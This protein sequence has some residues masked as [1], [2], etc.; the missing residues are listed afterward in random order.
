MRYYLL[1]VAMLLLMLPLSAWSRLDPCYHTYDEIIA[2]LDSL[3][4]VYPDIML[5]QQIGTTLGAPYCDPMPIWAAKI[6]DNVTT[7]EDE[8]AVM[9]AGQCH[10]EEVL[11]VEITMY[12]INDILTH[13]YQAPYNIWIQEIEMWFVPTYNPEGL[14]IVHSGL[15][16]T[17]RK[18]QRDNNGNGV[19]DFL[20]GPGGDIDGVDLNRNYSF[21]WIHGDTLYAGGSEEWN[22]YYRGP[23]PFSEGGTMAI[24]DLAAQQHIIFSINWHSSRTG[25]YSEKVFYSFEWEGV[26][27]SPDFD[28]NEYVGQSVAAL[29]E[30]EGG[31]GFYEPSPSRGRNGCAQDWFYKTHGTTQ[32]LIECGTWNLQPPEPIVIDTCE[33]CSEGAYWLLNRVIGYQ[34]DKAMLTGHITDASTSTPLEA[35]IILD[36]LQAS[37]LTPRLSDQLYGRYWRQLLPGTY[38]VR[39]CREGYQEQVFENVTVN[40]SIWTVRDAALQPLQPA[41]VTGNVTCD[42][43]PVAAEI[44]VLGRENDTLYTDA[45]G[46]YEFDD[47]EGEL[48]MLVRSSGCVPQFY[49]TVLAAGNHLINFSLA[50]AVAIFQEDWE[51]GLAGWN[52]NGTW[53]I[54]T[55]GS[56]NN[57]L[58]DSPTGFYENQSNHTIT[59][60][61]PVN[62][63]G[64]SDDV[65]LVLD[66]RYYVEYDN[67]ICSVELSTN[68][69]YWTEVAAFSGKI[70]FWHPE[71]VEITEYTDSYV[72]LRFRLH[73]D[74]SL[75]DPGWK[76]DNI[77]IIATTGAD[78]SY[79][80]VPPFVT[81]LYQN[82]PNPFNPSTAIRF[83]LEVSGNVLLA[84]YNLK[85]QLVRTLVQEN[86]DTGL[87]TFVWDGTDN[88]AKPAASGIYFYRLQAENYQK[89]R[90]MVLFK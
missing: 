76:I 45:S 20:P 68:G 83:S 60:L 56:G 53:A 87:H 31:G 19:F 90:K 48:H 5:V 27:R 15:D 54:S 81:T 72:Y 34:T 65:K 55:S 22:D 13:R 35:E 73:S 86:L 29:I 21:N 47:Y 23:Y 62:L 39:I 12:M 30:L 88:S 4:G 7:D 41:Y 40:N 17:F 1:M 79:P 24:R 26:K 10:A 50:P 36:E 84:V 69:S 66:H 2:E 46:Y 63:N 64:V 74:D 18:N 44:I 57:Y 70:D 75:N 67:D 33:R 8:P 28:F 80:E 49:E 78:S 52:V 43:E 9:Y 16:D 25:N 61:Q 85:G 51:S 42:G 77:G 38:T 82:S 89:I 11:G 59:T 32:L 6:S 3:Q 14:E 37:Y 58:D 71:V